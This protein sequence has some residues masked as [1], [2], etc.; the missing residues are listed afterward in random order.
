MLSIRWPVSHVEYSGR[1]QEDEVWVHRNQHLGRKE[2]RSKFGQRKKSKFGV[3]WTKPQKSGRGLQSDYCPSECS[4]RGLKG[5]VLVPVPYPP[6]E[7]FPWKS[8]RVFCSWGRPKETPNWRLSIC[9]L[10]SPNHSPSLLPRVF[11]PTHSWAASLFL[12]GELGGTS[13]GIPQPGFEAWILPSLIC[14]LGQILNFFLSQF[15]PL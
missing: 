14:D 1:R 9:W 11:S 5:L 12:K 13:P 6:D 4:T 10:H 15:T 2:G 3:V 7:S 8:E